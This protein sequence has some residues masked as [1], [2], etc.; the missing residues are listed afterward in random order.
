MKGAEARRAA[1]NAGAIAAASILSRGLQFGWQLILVPGLGPI[2]FGI[3]GAV[4]SFIQV[5][6]SVASFGIGPIYIR[7]I[8]RHPEQAGKY[9]TSTLFI[10]TILSFL[11]YLGITAAAYLGG[12]EESVR[13]FVALA[14]LNLMIDT[15]G[16]MCNDLLLARE[17]MVKTSVVT[18]CHIIL[19]ITL[20]GIGLASGYGILGVYIGSMIA[21]IVRA[22][23]FWILVRREGV[24]LSWPLDRSIALPLLLNGAPLALSSF[25][26]LL[27]QHVDKLVTNRYLGDADTGYLTVAF[28]IIFGVVDILS[29]TVLTALY[30]L[31]ARSYGDGHSPMFGFIVE[32]LTFYTL[33]LCLP[34]TLVVSLFSA[35]IMIPLFGEKYAPTAAVLSVLMWYALVMMTGNTVQQAF[36]VKNQQ[37]RLLVI[38]A[39]GLIINIALLFVFL[40]QVGVVGAPIASIGAE[41][42]VFVLFL[43]NFRAAGWDLRPLLPRFARLIALG[44]LTALVMLLLRGV[45]PVVGM[46]VGVAVYAAGVFLFRVLA[47]DD[48]DLLYRLVAAMPGGS[49]IRRYWHRDT[50][51]NW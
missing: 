6:T 32:K 37:R 47:N 10:Q 38:R 35:Q 34:I 41:S 43:F 12:Y 19:L 50:Q 25:L 2:A 40:S 8:A 46:V 17:Q 22:T 9:L 5:G 15:L 18:V 36:L 23:A 20:A 51:V 39:I 3:Y 11:A 4:S 33:I 26:S 29:T 14:G 1:R 16:N 24:R 21:G 45:Q 42:T 30:P 13:L 49:L 28:V 48:W 31:M 7:D 27:Y 44:L